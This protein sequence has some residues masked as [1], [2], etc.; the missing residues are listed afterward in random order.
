MTSSWT[1]V[2]PKA[3]HTVSLRREKMQRIR[4]RGHKDGSHVARHQETPEPPDAGQGR[5]DSFLETSESMW[6]CQHLDFRFLAPRT[7]REGVSAVFSPWVWG[8]L[9]EQPSETN[10]QYTITMKELSRRNKGLSTSPSP[11]ATAGNLALALC[12]LTS[13]QTAVRK[14]R[15]F[16]GFSV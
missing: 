3:S 16:R 6:P 13:M 11:P 5:E 2:G 8:H 9:L 14:F 1:R 12:N 7:T 4:P 10:T 15:V